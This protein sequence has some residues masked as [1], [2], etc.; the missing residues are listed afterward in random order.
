MMIVF[1]RVDDVWRDSDYLFEIKPSR[2]GLVLSDIR[3]EDLLPAGAMTGGDVVLLDENGEEITRIKFSPTGTANHT[4]LPDWFALCSLSDLTMDLWS[5]NMDWD[6]QREGEGCWVEGE[7][8][9]CPRYFDCIKAEP[10]HG[11]ENCDENFS[12]FYSE[13]E[14]CSKKGLS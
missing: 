5:T 1:E 9:C 14:W 4:D 11:C 3:F 13:A 7:G 8:C 12:Q 10:P 2:R 6:D